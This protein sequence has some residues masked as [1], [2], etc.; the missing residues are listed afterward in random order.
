MGERMRSLTRGREVSERPLSELTVR[1]VITKQE[2][3]M[4]LLG[5]CHQFVCLASKPNVVPRVPKPLVKPNVTDLVDGL[6][7]HDLDLGW[8]GVDRVGDVS[9][10]RD[11]DATPIRDTLA[12]AIVEIRMLVNEVVIASRTIEVDKCRAKGRYKTCR[13]PICHF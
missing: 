1:H 10:E 11:Q 2:G 5:N 7:R 9:L 3:G 12:K 8:R 6:R 13:K 4:L